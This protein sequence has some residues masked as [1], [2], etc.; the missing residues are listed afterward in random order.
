MRRSHL[1]HQEKGFLARLRVDELDRDVATITFFAATALNAP[2]MILIE[3][4]EPEAS[5]DQWPQ[6]A[7]GGGR[8]GSGRRGV[9]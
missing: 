2:E 4:F 3:K 5:C 1:D 8:H 9:D 6:P 7:A